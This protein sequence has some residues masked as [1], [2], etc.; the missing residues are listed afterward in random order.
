MS[1]DQARRGRPKGS[2]LDD[3]AQLRA[4]SR[5]LA[6][7]PLLKPTTAIK[8][9][10]VT[11][12]STI[13]RLRDKLRAANGSAKKPAIARAGQETVTSQQT[14]SSSRHRPC[15]SKRATHSGAAGMSTMAVMDPMDWLA[16]WYGAGWQAHSS[17]VEVHIAAVENLLKLPHVASAFRAQLL[18]SNN[19]IALSTS[20]GNISTTLH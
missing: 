15:R 1:V 19:V 5:L 17:M 12:P 14:A 4:I 3:R 2:G 11:D 20:S 7:D 9:I 8:S 10:G 6:A 18:L 13:R 16:A